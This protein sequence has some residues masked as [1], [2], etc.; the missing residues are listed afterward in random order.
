[1]T[2][3]TKISDSPNQKLEDAKLMVEENYFNKKHK[4]SQAFMPHRLLAVK[5]NT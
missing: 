2:R 4:I 5:G 1:M 3:K